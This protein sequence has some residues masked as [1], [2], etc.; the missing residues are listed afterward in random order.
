M[1]IMPIRISKKYIGHGKTF[2][3]NSITPLWNHLQRMY[4]D[5]YEKLKN[6]GYSSIT[7]ID[8]PSKV[9][10]KIQ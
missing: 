8:G 9:F 7:T 1:N 5:I 4:P 2:K 10:Q 3:S 6:V